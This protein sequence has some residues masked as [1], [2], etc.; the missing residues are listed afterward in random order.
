MAFGEIYRLMGVSKKTE[1]RIPQWIKELEIDKGS[2]KSVF[3]K[4]TGD[5][6]IFRSSYLEKPKK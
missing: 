5:I 3:I 1:R 2:L 4:V 6:L